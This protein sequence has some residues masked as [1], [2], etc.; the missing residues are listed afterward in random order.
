MQ[1]RGRGIAGTVVDAYQWIRGVLYFSVLRMPGVRSKVQKQLG[2]VTVQ[3]EKRLLPQ[4]SDFSHY[5][6]LPKEGWTDVQI[7]AELDKLAGM[8]HSR[9]EDGKVSGTVY[10]GGAELLKLQ[11]Q[12]YEKFSVANPIHPDVF[13][14]VRK[15]EAEVVA[16][17]LSLFNA[18][19]S[20]CGVMTSGGTES[21]LLACYSA[22][23]KAYH[24]RGITEP[25]MCVLPLSF[26]QRH[27]EGLPP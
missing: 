9:W 2:E 15:M 26:P 19:A 16:M 27:Y 7:T 11:A 6:A 4:G 14:G 20:A 23:Q 22:R 25:E 1:L 13:P 17:T 12:A 21:I 10:H 8:E 24:E 3:M 18:P 5:T